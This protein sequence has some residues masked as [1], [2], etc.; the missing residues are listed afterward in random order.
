MSSARIAK[1]QK[2]I[3]GLEEERKI[4][5]L[6]A[7]GDVTARGKEQLLDLIAKVARQRRFGQAEQLRNWLIEVDDTAQKE[8]LR[9]A[10]IIEEA[11]GVV[12]GSDGSHIWAGLFDVLTG[13]EFAAL[14][15]SLAF[16]KYAA[17]ELIVRR[18]AAHGSLFFVNS[19]EV[20]LFYREGGSE[21][22]VKVLNSG[23]VF[24]AETF[25]E[26]SVSTLSAAALSSTEIGQLSMEKLEK[27]KKDFPG[28]ES[29]LQSFSSMFNDV[30]DFFSSSG[31]DRR[32][33]ERHALT[34]PVSTI[35]L[36]ADGEPSGIH[37]E[38]ELLD[39]CQGGVSFFQR[40][41]RKENSRLLLGREIG[42]TLR[43]G[44]DGER[45]LPVGVV[46]AVRP[47][48]MK[49]FGYSVHVEFREQLDP[50]ILQGI[51]NQRQ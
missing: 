33:A 2:S 45:V 17:E 4:R 49:E 50:Q 1:Q 6:I 19:G 48:H 26:V 7:D 3:T 14:Y 20:K 32:S 37:T 41:S 30:K 29:K 39:I 51:L 35:L 12:V 18:G 31:R 27:L 25:F 5:E 21:I 22:L 44:T 42:M 47:R 10:E 43:Q 15:N 46:K 16:K 23:E 9:A 40:M 36:D 13:E 38:G 11:K 34:C 28:L 8:I 24:G